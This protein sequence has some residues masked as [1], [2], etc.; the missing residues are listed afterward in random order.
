M[1]RSFFFFCLL[2]SHALMAQYDGDRGNYTTIDGIDIPHALLR[3]EAGL[4]DRD[5]VLSVEGYPASG[6]GDSLHM[7]R[8]IFFQVG[9]GGLLLHCYSFFLDS[10]DGHVVD[11]VSF[12]GSCSWRRSYS[13]PY[14]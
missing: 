4:G 6:R 1:V 10:L 7:V 14:R 5:R 3:E 2:F 12:V 13:P 8:A 9:R 11:G